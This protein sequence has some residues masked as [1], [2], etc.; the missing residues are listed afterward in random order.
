MRGVDDREAGMHAL[1]TSRKIG[2]ALMATVLFLGGLELVLRVVLEEVGRATIPSQEVE[3]HVRSAGMRYDPDL[4]WTWERVPQPEMGIDENA[5]RHPRI[6]KRKPPGVW[7]GFT[8]GDSQ[9][10][11]AG[12]KWD[13]TYTAVAER[14]LREKTHGGKKVELIN[15]AVSGYHS[16]NALRLIETK[17]LDWDPDVIVIDCF[18]FDSP[19]EETLELKSNR[20]AGIRKYLFY[21][22]IYYAMEFVIDRLRPAQPRRMHAG[23]VP[24]NVDTQHMGNHDLIVNLGIQRGYKTVFV[25]YPFWDQ[26]EDKV[27]CLVEH[28]DLPP[29]APVVDACV[30]LLGTG[31]PGS[32]LFLDNNHPTPHGHEIIGRALAETLLNADL[33][34]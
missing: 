18:T 20:F 15:A 28:A 12:V 14:I 5:F 13:E 23:P 21:S 10:Y 17:L 7:R 9:T 6:D 11:G 27:I 3:N 30:A 1:S 26:R 8:I 4:G 33:G 32:K 25:D 2:Y 16:L 24:G 22:R 19:R 31:E 29:G 34:L